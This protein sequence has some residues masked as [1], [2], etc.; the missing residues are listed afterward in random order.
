MFKAMKKVAERVKAYRLGDD[1]SEIEQLISS[2]KIIPRDNG[3]FEIMSQE[4]VRGN[5]GKGEVARTGDYVKLDALGYPYP[6]DAEFF[7]KNHKWIAENEYMQIPIPLDAWTVDEPMCEEIEFLICKKALEIH[8]D[9]PE[10]YFSAMLWGTKESA[11]R[12]AVIVFYNI[13]RN[14]S[15]RIID[16]SYNFV[17]RSEFERT[18]N[19]WK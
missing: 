19:Y 6:N 5:S 8:T 12:D 10:N 4:A 9:S 15:G 18:Y 14:E 17:C 16:A 7:C 2:G 3:F 13:T 11:A 1:G